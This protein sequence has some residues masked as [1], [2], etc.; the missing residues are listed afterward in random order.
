MRRKTEHGTA[1]GID[2]TGRRL[3][4]LLLDLQRAH[5]VVVIDV[6]FAAGANASKLGI[7]VMICG[8]CGWREESDRAR[9][10]ERENAGKFQRSVLGEGRACC[11]L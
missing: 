10:R 3:L 4:R 7:A 5:S 6:V 8:L 9:V 11:A 2:L 1:A